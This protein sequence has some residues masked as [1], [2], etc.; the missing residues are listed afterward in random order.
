M[1]HP[2]CLLT[3]TVLEVVIFSLEG[4]S[5]FDIL[6]LKKK[7]RIAFD[8]QESYLVGLV[9]LFQ[10]LNLALQQGL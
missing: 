10:F 9:K 2:G 7:Y 5:V 1:F 4:R 6:K 8:F 3:V